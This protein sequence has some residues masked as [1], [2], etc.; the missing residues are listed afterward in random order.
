MSTH[1]LTH[2]FPIR[3][4]SDKTGRTPTCSIAY[5]TRKG[6]LSR[7][8]G[9]TDRNNETCQYQRVKNRLSWYE[10]AGHATG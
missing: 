3:I 7:S 8:F 2:P 4:D 9:D 6:H 1:P 10:H 5:G